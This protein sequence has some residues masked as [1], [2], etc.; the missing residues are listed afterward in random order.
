MNWPLLDCPINLLTFQT[1]LNNQSNM[2]ASAEDTVTIVLAH[3][4]FGDA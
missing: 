2:A 4:D 3:A 1:K